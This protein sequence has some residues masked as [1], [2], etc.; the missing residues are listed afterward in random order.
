MLV[1][2]SYQSYCLVLISHVVILPKVSH[3]K[4]KNALS[5]NIMKCKLS[6]FHQVFV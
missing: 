4:S 5:H 1:G 2:Q 3:R 6:V